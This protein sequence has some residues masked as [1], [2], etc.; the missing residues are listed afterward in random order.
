MPSFCFLAALLANN[1]RRGRLLIAL[2]CVAPRC[3]GSGRRGSGLR[4]GFTHLIH[5]LHM[6]G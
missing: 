3:V 2:R 1:R 5:V 6:V 4:D